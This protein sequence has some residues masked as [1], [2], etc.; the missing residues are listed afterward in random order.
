MRERGRFLPSPA[1][2]HV[3]VAAR[4]SGAY[5]SMRGEVRRRMG[6]GGRLAGSYLTRGTAPA[7]AGSSGGTGRGR[8]G[9]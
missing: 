1:L 3:R 2:L 8:T 6:V 7:C 5:S 4:G 9:S